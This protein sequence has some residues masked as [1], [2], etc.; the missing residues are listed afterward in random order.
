LEVQRW[1]LKVSL[2]KNQ[3]REMRDKRKALAEELG[4]LDAS[5]WLG[6]P[7]DFPNAKEMSFAELKNAAEKYF[8]R[9]GLVSHWYGK[10][11]SAQ[12][13]NRQL[14]KAVPKNDA[15][16][17]AVW[18][19]LP[20][21]PREQGPLPGQ[22]G[23]PANVKA[24][25]VFPKTNRFLLDKFVMEGLCGFLIGRR[26]PLFIWHT[27]L[28]WKEFYA[29]AG[30]FPDLKIIVE[31]QPQKILY[32][33]RSLMPLM[34]SRQN[35]LLE[36]SNFAGLDYLEYGVRTLGAE[37]FIFGSFLP[38]NDPL[39]PVGMILDADIS[40]ADKRAVAGGNLKRIM[41]GVKS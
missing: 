25:R 10:S 6:P 9:G 8:I 26:M 2:M 13:S 16:F 33:M 29:F 24:V 30:D 12:E 21:F 18:T 5:L 11:V 39:A 22:S 35:V 15:K 7:E 36:I 37:R 14:L 4:F 31:S 23:M 17:H 3:I 27:E 34:R 38:V 40:L 19:G 28:D 1:V 41:E 32:H 20:L